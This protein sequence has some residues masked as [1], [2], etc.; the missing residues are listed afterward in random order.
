MDVHNAFLHGDLHEEVYI[1]LPLGFSVGYKGKVCRLQK[2][3]YGLRQAPRYWFAK[4]I[5]ALKQYDFRQSYSDYSLF[6][7]YAQDIFLCVLVY[8]DNLIVTG[9]SVVALHHFKQHLSCRF[10]MKDLGS[11]KY[12]LGIDVAK[13]QKGIYFV[14]MQVCYGYTVECWFIRG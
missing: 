9:N 6:A 14:S 10:Y 1:K 4:L 8:V 12:F 5:A 2:S 11:L 7:Y 13:N 3:L